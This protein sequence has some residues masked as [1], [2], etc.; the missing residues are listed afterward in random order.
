M[1]DIET[2]TP[3]AKARRGIL[4]AQRAVAAASKLPG[5]SGARKQIAEVG[6]LARKIRR[7]DAWAIEFDR[8]ARRHGVPKIRPNGSPHLRLF[9]VL[10][11]D[12]PA[13]TLNRYANVVETCLL[14]EWSPAEIQRR[15]TLDGPE[16]ILRDYPRRRRLRRRHTAA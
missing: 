4:A 16:A 13:S 1:V 11:V 15:V 2:E 14:Y 12:R 10:G 3:R 7:R 9:R 5:Q 6:A 8:F